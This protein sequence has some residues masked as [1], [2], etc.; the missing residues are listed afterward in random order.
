MS[1][2]KRKIKLTEQ[3]V[4]EIVQKVEKTYTEK[5]L[6]E[7]TNLFHPDHRKISFLNHFSLMMAFQIYNIY[8]EIIKLEILDLTEQKAIFTYTRKHLYTCINEQDENGENLNNISSFYVHIQVE[9]RQI[10]ITKYDKYSELFL[11]RDGELLPN[12]QAVVPQNAQ[13][14][15]NMKRFIEPFQLDD[16]QPATYLLYEDSELLGYYPKGEQYSFK[17][18]EKFTIDYFTK[19]EADSIADHTETYITGNSLEYSEIVEIDENHSIVETK[20]MDGSNLLHELVLS[21]IASDGFYMIRYLKNK[22]SPIT[23]GMRESWMKQMKT[24]ATRI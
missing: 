19:M 18:T 22:N 9:D 3:K 10:W 11:N 20:I 16:F 21:I 2:F 4:R 23:E 7:L 24:S 13:F 12:E 1:F 14:F 8:S 17:T 6:E 5:D 15:E